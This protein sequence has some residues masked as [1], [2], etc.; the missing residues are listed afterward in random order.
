MNELTIMTVIKAIGDACQ[1]DREA[2]IAIGTIRDM[3]A[4]VSRA[5]MDTILTTLAQQGLIITTPE[6]NQKAITSADQYNG[7]QVGGEIKHYLRLA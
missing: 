5:D 7:I 3:A 4:G 6:E 2:W 1:A